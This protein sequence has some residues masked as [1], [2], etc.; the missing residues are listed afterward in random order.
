[1]LIL[2]GSLGAR[3]LN[4][5]VLQAAFDQ[6]LQDCQLILACGAQ[7]VATIAKAGAGLPNLIVKSYID[8]IHEYM[9]AADL[10]VC[11]AGA[12]T[13]AEVAALCRPTIMVPYPH[14]AGDHQ[15]A[16]AR[17]FAKINA[18]ILCPDNL[19]DGPYLIARLKELLSDPER[20]QEMSMAAATLAR[21]RAAADIVDQISGLLI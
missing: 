2:G 16:N 5:A 8:N 10:I 13:C 1:V 4:E 11:R 20:L 3:T 12:I 15:T 7:H 9:A 14:A 18:S 17:I 6:S 19:F 21:P